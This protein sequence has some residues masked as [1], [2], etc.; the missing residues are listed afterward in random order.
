VTSYGVSTN[1]NGYAPFKATVD[2]VTVSASKSTAQDNRIDAGYNGLSTGIYLDTTRF[3]IES[4]DQ[5][6]NRVFHGPVSEV[7]I[8]ETIPTTGVTGST[9]TGTFDVTSGGNSVSIAAQAGIADVEAALEGLPS[10]G[11]ISVSTN[12]IT[13]DTSM[14]C[15]V[16]EGGNMIVIDD[17]TGDPT[18]HFS[19]GDWIRLKSSTGPVYTIES[20]VKTAINGID[21]YKIY[22]SSA[23][24]G[25]TEPFGVTTD[26]GHG[27]PY[28]FVPV[29]KGDRDGYQYIITFDS[30]LG[31][32]EALI[33][34][35]TNLNSF[36][37]TS[38]YT[39]ATAEV[40]A[41]D[42]L[43]RQVVTTTASVG[44]DIAGTFNL[45]MDGHVTG[46]LR[47]DISEADLKAEL[48]LWDGIYAVTVERSVADGQGGYS[49]TITFDSYDTTPTAVYAEGHLLRLGSDDHCKC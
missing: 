19:E 28:G 5:F 45:Q 1:R 2:A 25:Y 27:Y 31:D 9:L 34:D 49:W 6:S 38:T 30:N 42:L 24:S 33:V 29:Y 36:D 37:G 47:H 13:T 39:A 15:S 11:D 4:R 14:T 48:E 3:T 22:I 35:Y 16:T 43:I 17:G 40:T 18:S 12:S 23:Y 20:I 10:L 7:Q 46:D 8:I 41:C 26:P 21:T 44:E 32:L